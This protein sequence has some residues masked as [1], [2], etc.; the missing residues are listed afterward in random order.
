MPINVEWRAQR[1]VEGRDGERR[2]DGE[3]LA[4]A[5]GDASDVDRK[6]RVR[7]DRSEVEVGRGTLRRGAG[8]PGDDHV[9]QPNT[10][11]GGEV[12]DGELSAALQPQRLETLA[13]LVVVRRGVRIAGADPE[14]RMGTVAGLWQD[15]RNSFAELRVA[16]GSG[17]DRRTEL[18]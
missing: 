12:I 3:A 16:A 10:V 4:E 5:L 13:D 18:V 14:L 11:A 1:C 7:D 8:A 6:Q 17:A 15:F 2:E 9:C